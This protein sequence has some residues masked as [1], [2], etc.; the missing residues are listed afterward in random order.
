M[1]KVQSEVLIRFEGEEKEDSSDSDYIPST[2]KSKKK[3]HII[4]KDRSGFKVAENAEKAAE[5][6]EEHGQLAVEQTVTFD[7]S[8]GR[9]RKRKNDDKEVDQQACQIKRPKIDSTASQSTPRE[10]AGSST[11]E[12]SNSSTCMQME[13]A[14]KPQ[15]NSGNYPYDMGDIITKIE[16]AAMSMIPYRSDSKHPP[17]PRTVETGVLTPQGEFVLRPAPIF[18]AHGLVLVFDYRALTVRKISKTQYNK[19]SV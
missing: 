18:H 2:P 13:E 12:N 1:T 9:E 6:T 10:V 3:V 16:E 8:S 11:Q 19:H 4:T 5:P 14:W 17:V 7:V 15:E